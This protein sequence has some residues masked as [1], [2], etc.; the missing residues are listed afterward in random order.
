MTKAMNYVTIGSGE[1][2]TLAASLYSFEQIAQS[3]L[4]SLVG[5]GELSE[6]LALSDGKK[7]SRV[8]AALSKKGGVIITIE[9]MGIRG[10]GIDAA[11]QRLQEEVHDTIYDLTEISELKVN[12]RV[13]SLLDGKRK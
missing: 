11:V 4:E 7:T 1:G 9:V 2:G 10:S 6:S 3:T 8:S 5:E 13:C 12:V